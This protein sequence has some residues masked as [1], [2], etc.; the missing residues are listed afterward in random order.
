MPSDC[1]YC[2]EPYLNFVDEDGGAGLWIEKTYDGEHVIAADHPDASGTY[3]W[4][5]PINFCQFC[6][7]NLMKKVDVD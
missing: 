5:I 6:G 4:S 1:P 7:R 3:A 2:G